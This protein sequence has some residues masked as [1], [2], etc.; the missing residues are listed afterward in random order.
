MSY[1]GIIKT[2]VILGN[3][4]L[5]TGGYLVYK[6]LYA[7]YLKFK[8]ESKRLADGGQ[9]DYQYLIDAF[10]KEGKEGQIVQVNDISFIGT[11]ETIS[12]T[13]FVHSKVNKIQKFI[14]VKGTLHEYN[15][16][17]IQTQWVKAFNLKDQNNHHVIVHVNN[18]DSFMPSIFQKVLPP[19]KEE[20]SI[21]NVKEAFSVNV[22]ENGIAFGS[23]LYVFGNFIKNKLGQ[24]Q[25]VESKVICKAAD[26]R[27]STQNYSYAYFVGAACVATLCLLISGISIYYTFQQPEEKQN[28][29]RSNRR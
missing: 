15:K 23:S 8:K 10:N 6:M 9:S 19:S 27:N 26:A 1:Q 2:G 11:S 14:C 7:N 25:C 12:P 4:L 5:L 22:S 20:G 13:T 29:V 18:K 28:K 3:A 21:E 17:I 24:I 16:D